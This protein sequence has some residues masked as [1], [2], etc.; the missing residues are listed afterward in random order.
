MFV[1]IEICDDLISHFTCWFSTSCREGLD[2]YY[3]CG[4][5]TSI[6]QIDAMSNSKIHRLGPLQLKIMKVLWEHQPATVAEVNGALEG[7]AELAYTTIATMLRKMELRGLV[8]HEIQGRTFLYRPAIAE[9]EVASSLADDLLDR[10]FEGSLSDMVSHL[11]S[12]R[13]VSRDELGR[14]EKLI[15]E[16]K[17]K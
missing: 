7:N 5:I 9:V 1:D 16:R 11:L 15:A 17:K 6:V 2:N 8:T 4:S 13:E 3:Y 10:V 12:S 14:L